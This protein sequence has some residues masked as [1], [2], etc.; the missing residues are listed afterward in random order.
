MASGTVNPSLRP[1]RRPG[2]AIQGGSAHALD[3]FAPL[4][5]TAI[6]E[7]FLAVLPPA[8]AGVAMT[9]ERAM[10]TRREPFLGQGVY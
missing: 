10:G 7:R 3:C 6:M 4:A 8:Y 5:M 9:G 1:W 2:E